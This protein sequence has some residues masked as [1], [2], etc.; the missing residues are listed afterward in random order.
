MTPISLAHDRP[1]VFDLRAR[2]YVQPRCAQS[3]SDLALFPSL[4]MPVGMGIEA[5]T[6]LALTMSTAALACA[7]DPLP[8]GRRL[9]RKPTSKRKPHGYAYLPRTRTQVR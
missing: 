7:D 5:K 4:V 1:V 6:A 2:V 3:Q 8:S 9:S